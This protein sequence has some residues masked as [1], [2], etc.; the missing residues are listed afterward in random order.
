MLF[1]TFSLGGE[2]YALEAERA[3]EV[4]PLVDLQ[5]VLHPPPGIAGTLNY[6]GEFVPVLDL[7]RMILGRPA[8]ARLSTRILVIRVKQDQGFRLLG[9]IAEKLTETMRCDPSDF[10]SPGIISSETPFLGSVHVDERG[11]VQRID[12]DR[13]LAGQQRDLLFETPA[14]A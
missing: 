3:L 12:V 7:S 6:H 2:R 13:L 9:V 8:P 11:S 14:A 4:L 1:L 10:V 5:A